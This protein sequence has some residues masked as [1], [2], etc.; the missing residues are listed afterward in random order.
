MVGVSKKLLESLLDDLGDSAPGK[1]GAEPE[2][3]TDE[4]DLPDSLP[5]DM[6]AT[7]TVQD[8]GMKREITACIDGLQHAFGPRIERILGSGEG[9]I[10]ILDRVGIEDD[11]K[12][13]KLSR[14]IPVA[15]I[16]QRTLAGLAR[17]GE[18]SPIGDSRVVYDAAEQEG[19]KTA[20]R[21]AVLAREKLQAA[22]LLLDQAC[23]SGALEL[24]ISAL[25]SAA[26]DRADAQTAVSPQDAGVWLYGEALPKGL[27]TQEEAALIM[28]AITLGQ[29]P[30]VPESLLTDLRLDVEEFVLGAAEGMNG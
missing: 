27:L 20:S 30:S 24:L 17:L 15:L 11:Q 6:K 14:R 29:S 10:T 2:E 19:E 12:A 8:D 9:L 21:L 5:E 26:A 13:E 23:A 16:D 7:G 25:L 4:D 22:N 1:A 28:R 18:G 3:R